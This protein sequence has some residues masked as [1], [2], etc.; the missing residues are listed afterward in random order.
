MHHTLLLDSRLVDLAYNRLI[1][2]QRLG[3]FVGWAALNRPH[4]IIIVAIFQILDHL[5]DVLHDHL[6]LIEVTP[7]RHPILDLSED[8]RGDFELLIVH[9]GLSD[10]NHFVLVILKNT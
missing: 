2:I 6:P 8:L 9:N 3:G 7:I 10:I 5:V 4:E 1:F